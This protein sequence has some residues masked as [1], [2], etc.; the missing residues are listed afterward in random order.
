MITLTV[1][2]HDN[3]ERL[4]VEQAI[5]F[6]RQFRQLAAAPDGAVLRL[7]QTGA[8]WKAAHVGPSWSY[9]PW[10]TGRSGTPSG[11]TDRQ[12]PKGTLRRA[13]WQHKNN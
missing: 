10:W 3:A 2:C 12:N 13:A 5:A 9:A 6:V 1:Q 8:R 7:K 11:T 4:A